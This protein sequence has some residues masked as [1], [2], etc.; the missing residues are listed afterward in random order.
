[1]KFIQIDRRLCQ[2]CGGCVS[3]CSFLA[4]KIEFGQLKLNKHNCKQCLNCI[5][6]CP[7]AALEAVEE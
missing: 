7:N 2:A 3:V 6:V 1:M 5:Q 4:L